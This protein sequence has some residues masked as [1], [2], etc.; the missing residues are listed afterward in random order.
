MPKRINKDEFI[1]RYKEKFPQSDLTF[2]HLIYNGNKKEVLATCPKHGDFKTTPNL[3]MGGCGCAKCFRERLKLRRFKKEEFTQRFYNRF[4]NSNMTFDNFIYGGSHY[5]SEATC[6]K[7]GN[8]KTTPNRLMSGCGCAECWLE[9]ARKSNE[10]FKEE[11]YNKFPNSKYDLSKFVYKNTISSSIAICPIHGD[12][13]IRA[14]SLLKG[15][16]CPHCKCSHSENDIKTLLESNNI[17]FE[18]NK[19]Y[20]WLDKLQLDFYLPKYK[21]A[22]ECQGIQHFEPTKFGGTT[23]EKAKIMFEKC[24]ERD[25]HKKKLCENNGVKLLYYAN[26]KYDFP[27]EVITDKNKLIE[28]ITKNGTKD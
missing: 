28:E 20:N 14:D 7:H 24:I 3:L 1:Q 19:Y 25:K 2:E 23:L 22:I 27:Y 15:G 9:N 13:N 12:F 11:Y 18:Y 8:F 16:S 17:I 21:I 26:F 5:E 4:P 6:P 10:E